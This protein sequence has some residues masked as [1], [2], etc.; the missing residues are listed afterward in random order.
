MRLK[1]IA[2]S[3]RQSTQKGCG[4]SR[5]MQKHRHTAKVCKS[6]AEA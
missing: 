5:R 3:F 2:A 1:E 6:V 4:S